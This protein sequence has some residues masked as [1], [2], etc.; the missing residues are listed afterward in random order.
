MLPSDWLRAA[1][2][3]VRIFHSDLPVFS[4]SSSLLRLPLPLPSPLLLSGPPLILKESMT[5]R[6]PPPPSGIVVS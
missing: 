3:H 2:A 5:F 6:G 1:R 4:A